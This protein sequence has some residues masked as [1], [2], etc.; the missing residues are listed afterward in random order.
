M[1]DLSRLGIKPMSPALAGWFL[2]AGP[3]GKSPAVA[4]LPIINS[5]NCSYS[6]NLPLIP[7]GRNRNML[8][9]RSVLF[10]FGSKWDRNSLCQPHQ[11]LGW[12]FQV[13]LA[14]WQLNQKISWYFA[15]LFDLSPSFPT[16]SENRIHSL[17]ALEDTLTSLLNRIKGV[18]ALSPTGLGTAKGTNG[19][20]DSVLGPL[21]TYT[22]RQT[23]KSTA[24]SF[25]ASWTEMCGVPDSEEQPKQS[26]D[27]SLS[28]WDRPGKK[29]KLRVEP[30]KKCK[31]Q[32]NPT[33]LR[34]SGN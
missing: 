10:C 1:W 25:S 19:T 8:S 27:M 4:F 5:L 34:L 33:T 23:P 32:A 13:R 18:V 17:P 26:S 6:K 2:T 16:H 22:P 7:Q 31:G 9:S 11:R 29:L 12:Q 21:G 20:T 28:F 3:P 14:S 24:W 15:S 30:G